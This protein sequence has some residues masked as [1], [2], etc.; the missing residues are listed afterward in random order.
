MLFCKSNI[1]NSNVNNFASCS[2][3]NDS[4]FIKANKRNTTKIQITFNSEPI[5]AKNKFPNLPQDV[6][7]D[8]NPSAP[9]SPFSPKFLP[10]LVR[11]SKYQKQIL[12]EL[13]EHFNEPVHITLA[14]EMLMMLPIDAEHHRE[15]T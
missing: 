4:G 12:K 9:P 5:N 8:G 7:E 14:R 1:D 15:I 2:I 6:S 3:D 10:I 11:P 13:N